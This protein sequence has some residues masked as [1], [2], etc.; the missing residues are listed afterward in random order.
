MSAPVVALIAVTSVDRVEHLV[1]DDAMAA[2]R[3][4]GRY[5]ALCGT[6]VL[7]ASLATVERERCDSCR[8]HTGAVR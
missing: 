7:S 6:T 4:R 3:S 2:G 8:R 1:R 5:V